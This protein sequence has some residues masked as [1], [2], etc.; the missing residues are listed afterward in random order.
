MTEKKKR[1]RPKAAAPRTFARVFVSL[2]DWAVVEL[3]R[4]KTAENRRSIADTARVILEAS[5]MESRKERET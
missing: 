5:L 1:G 3:E 2:A 4:I